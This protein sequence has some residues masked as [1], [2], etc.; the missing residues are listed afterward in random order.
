MSRKPDG[1]G[2]KL[3][4]WVRDTNNTIVQLQRMGE[5]AWHHSVGE[6]K[7][8]CDKSEKRGRSA[9]GSKTCMGGLLH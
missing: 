6:F 5:M 4:N 8:M 7:T 2:T 1:R 9:D 3:R